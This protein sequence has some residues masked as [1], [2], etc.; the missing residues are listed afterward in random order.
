VER[1]PCHPFTQDV[2]SF[3]PEA[4][5][6]LRSRLDRF[7]REQLQKIGVVDDAEDEQ[8]RQKHLCR[9]LCEDLRS[10]GGPMV[11]MEVKDIRLHLLMSIC[12]GLTAL[13]EEEE[14]VPPL[15]MKVSGLLRNACM[16]FHCGIIDY[17]FE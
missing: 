13:F 17:G 5:G 15:P 7:C 10:H 16:P 3:S 8:A 12:M 14:I 2:L 6:L 1:E 11:E 4:N 9:L